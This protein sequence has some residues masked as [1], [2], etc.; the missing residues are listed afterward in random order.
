MIKVKRERERAKRNEKV[1][2]L[3]CRFAIQ[4]GK[5]FSMQVIEE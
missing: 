1:F 3:K 2:T 4:V 5:K